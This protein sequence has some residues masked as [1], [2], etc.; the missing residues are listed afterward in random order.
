MH[1][2]GSQLLPAWKHLCFQQGARELP[3]SPWHLGRTEQPV[4]VRHGFGVCWD[5]DSND[6][7]STQWKR[8]ALPSQLEQSHSRRP[9]RG[10]K[11]NG[12]VAGRCALDESLAEGQQGGAGGLLDEPLGRA[13]AAERARHLRREPLRL[14]PPLCLRSLQSPLRPPTGTQSVSLGTSSPPCAHPMSTIQSVWGTSSPPCARPPEFSQS[15]WGPAVPPAPHPMSISQSVW[16]PALR[17]A[18]NQSPSVNLS[19]G[20]HSERGA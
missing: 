10:G 4:D 5:G 9:L 15:V 6:T 18:P 19:G 14:H 1:L 16:G 3:N 20:Q 13:A 2:L 11:Q 8:L 12:K 17:S 7:K